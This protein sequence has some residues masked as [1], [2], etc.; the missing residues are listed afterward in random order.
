MKLGPA[1]SKLLVESATATGPQ[2]MGPDI[3]VNTADS[4]LTYIVDST[5]VADAQPFRHIDSVSMADR[6]HPHTIDSTLVA[7]LHLP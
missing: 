4:N 2:P 7:D 6:D 1:S 5:V 3:S